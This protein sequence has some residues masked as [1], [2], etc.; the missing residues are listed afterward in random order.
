MLYCHVTITNT[1]TVGF[2]QEV[3]ICPFTGYGSRRTCRCCHSPTKHFDFR[4]F[5]SELAHNGPLSQ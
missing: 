1:L 2:K 5:H 3:F 4:D